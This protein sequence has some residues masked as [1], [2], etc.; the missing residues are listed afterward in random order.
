M[1]FSLSIIVVSTFILSTT[2]KA[3][4][5][6]DPFLNN[7]RLSALEA[8]II[9]ID[10][11]SSLLKNTLELASFD[12]DTDINASF[13]RDD[14]A[15]F[16]INSASRNDT[17]TFGTSVSK[18]WRSGFKT[19]F[20]YEV[21]DQY[22]E[23]PTFTDLSYLYPTTSI[24]VTTNVFQDLFGRRYKYQA[25]K[26]SQNEKVIEQNSNNQLRSLLATA[27]LRLA[28]V[29]EI[30]D[31]LKLQKRLCTQVENQTTQL[32][33]KNKRGSIPKREYLLS[34]KEQNT[35]QATVKAEEKKRLEKINAFEAK[36]N[37]KVA[38]YLLVNIKDAFMEISSIY[39]KYTGQA[40]EVSFDDNPDIKEIS[41]R[42]S[43]MENNVQELRT[44]TKLDI[45]LT[46]KVGSSGVEDNFGKANEQAFKGENPFIYAGLTLNLPSTNRT[47][48]V[49]HTSKLLDLESLRKRKDLA[50]AQKVSSFQTLKESLMKDYEI[51]KDYERNVALSESILK[52]AR[53]DFN[54]G[55]IDFFAYME[56]QKGLI[57]SR[58]RLGELRT[59]III[60]TVEFFDYFNFFS[61]FY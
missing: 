23:Y 28:E 12:I 5:L 53:R 27:L 37:V 55:R 29:L 35:C 25:Q 31:D 50:W 6:I 13:E 47:E 51:Y 41:Q 40:K 15:A 8:K 49:N 1:K 3:S 26:I 59:Q 2:V 9:E 10:K 58:Q 48:R 30:Q 57:Q 46:L 21:K 16:N 36:F 19:Q 24:S 34:L 54:N 14:S 43:A 17:Y 56:F 32:K 20:N 38:P 4:T 39:T 22:F 60:N 44:Q 33:E 52:E 18:L 11:N 45:D 42:I 7:V 61:K